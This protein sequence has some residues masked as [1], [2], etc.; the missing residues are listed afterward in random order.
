VEAGLAFDFLSLRGEGGATCGDD[1][2][3]RFEV[4]NVLVDDRLVDSSTMRGL[5]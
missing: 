5:P 3:E 2:V 1:L 4:G